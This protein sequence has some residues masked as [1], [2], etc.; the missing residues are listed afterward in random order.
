MKNI[1]ILIVAISVF[2][3]S[4]QDEY[5]APVSNTVDMAGRWWTQFYFDGDL[6][7]IPLEENI[8]YTY[9]DFGGFGLTTSNTSANDLDSVIID[10]TE[11]SWPFRI[12]AP[13]NL[14]NLT[15]TPSTVLNIEPTSYLGSGETV[16]IIDGKI[17]KG[18]ARSKSGNVADSIYLLF[19]FSDDPGSYYIYTGHRDSG[20]T[21]DQY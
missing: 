7:G 21:E 19:E 16:S 15:F 8:I 18:A 1:S 17:L 14:S 13:V 6:S 10:D 12:K 4:C 11:G 2:F 3:A 5:K 20:L 9:A